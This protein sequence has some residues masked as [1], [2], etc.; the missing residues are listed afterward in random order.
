VRQHSI[1]KRQY[2]ERNDRHDYIE[3]EEG[4]HRIGEK[5]VDE[6]PHIESVID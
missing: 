5:L 3:R 4:R 2:Q 1:Q 6:Q